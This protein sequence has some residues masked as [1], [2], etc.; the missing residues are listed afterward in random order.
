MAN[1]LKAYMTL[2]N[3]TGTAMAERLGISPGYLSRLVSGER[4]ADATLLAT[5]EKGT[6]GQVT[7]DAWVRWWRKASREKASC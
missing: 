5:I 4:E 3:T 1:P 2:T 6:D 7:P